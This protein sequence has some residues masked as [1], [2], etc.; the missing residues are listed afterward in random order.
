[1]QSRVPVRNGIKRPYPDKITRELLLCATATTT[2]TD[3][4]TNEACWKNQ[5]ESLF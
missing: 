2:T 1:M 4:P 5:V 3:Q